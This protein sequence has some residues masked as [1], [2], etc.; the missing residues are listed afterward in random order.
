MSSKKPKEENIEKLQDGFLSIHKILFGDDEENILHLKEVFENLKENSSS[1]SSTNPNLITIDLNESI[2]TRNQ[3]KSSFNH[4]KEN[5]E[6]TN[7]IIDQE[8]EE[9]EDSSKKAKN[10]TRTKK[11]DEDYKP[12][13]EEYEFSDNGGMITSRKRRAKNEIKKTTTG[14]KIKKDLLREMREFTRI[15]QNSI[16]YDIFY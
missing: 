10:K 4:L 12:I 16:E 13:E 1:N 11:N 14:K 7:I 6:T 3:K 8:D 9:K 5:K 2:K 15:T